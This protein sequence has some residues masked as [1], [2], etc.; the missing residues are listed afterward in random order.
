MDVG[1]GVESVHLRSTPGDGLIELRGLNQ[2]IFSGM[3][4]TF[5]DE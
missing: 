3:D 2:E 4:R 5:I 1:F